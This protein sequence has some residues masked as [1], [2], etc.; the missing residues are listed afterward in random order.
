MSEQ[1]IDIATGIGVLGLATGLVAAMTGRRRYALMS[2]GA[3]VAAA[4]LA[5]RDGREAS[6]LERRVSS[7]NEQI[8]QLENAVAAQ[9]QSRMAAEEAVKSLSTQLTD[10]ER[11]AGDS[12]RPP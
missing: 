6:D 2:A 4:L 3:A 1:R 7:M 8:R 10:A 5:R 11:R 12:S 9:V